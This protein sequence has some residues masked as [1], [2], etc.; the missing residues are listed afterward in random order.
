[1]SFKLSPAG[2]LALAVS[3]LLP[4]ALQAQATGH[5]H[6]HPE[7]HADADSLSAP[8][9]R[10]PVIHAL[11]Q[12]DKAERTI[13]G[14]SQSPVE[15]APVTTRQARVMSTAEGCPDYQGFANL[16]GQ[17][18]YDFVV[19]SDFECISELYRQNDA[20]AVATY[21]S[22]NVVAVA[23]LA[24][25]QAASYDSRS[26]R[27]MQQLFYFLRG[28]FYIEFYND[29]LTYSDNSASQAVRELLLEYA[30]NPYLMDT[31]DYAGR[32][33]SEFFT[34]WDS[35]YN[36]AESVPYVLDY[37]QAF[38]P[39]YL[40]SWS[41]RSA[42]TS[43][44]TVLYRGYWVDEYNQQ[45]EQYG[46]LRKA[47]LNIATADYII[48]SEYAYESSD[49]L[50][51][52]G[53]FYVYHERWGLSDALKNELN[54]GIQQYMAKFAR[55]SPQWADGAGYLDY[56]NPGQCEAFGIC[57]WEQELEQTVLGINYVCSDSI[58]IRAQA[59]NDAEL[60]QSCDLMAAEEVLFHQV[61][62]TGYTPVADD[63]NTSL[64]V[65][66]FDDYTNYDNYA[67][68]I[69]G[70]D[71]NNGGMYLE[72]NP[73]DQNNQARFIAHE[74]SWITDEFVVWNLEHEYV[75]YLDGR[76]NLY[77]AFNYFDINTGKS[78]WWSE[79]LAEYLSRQNRNDEAVALARTGALSL[80][81]VLATT[82]NDGT[83][84]VYRWGYL[85]VRFMFE[86]HRS[87]VD[88]M[89]ALA[90]GGDAQGWLDY[91]NNTIADNYEAEW[92]QWLQ[93]VASNDS[94]LTGP[95]MP[96][97]SDGDGVPDSQDAFPN[98]P[99]ETLDTDG[100]GIG[101]NAD[102]DDDND[103]YEDSLDLFPLD[104]TEWADSDGDGIG[105][106]A[107][108][109]TGTPTQDC[110]AATITDGN[111]T[112]D[113]QEC[114]AGSGINYY[115][116]YVDADNTQ[117]TLNL[118]GGTGEVDILFNQ[119][120]WATESAFDVR[121]DVAGSDDS[122]T[123][124]AN[125]GWVYFSLVTS[126]GYQGV[127]MTLSQGGTEPEPELP[128]NV[129]DVCQAQTPYEYGGVNF[130]EAVCVADGRTSYYFYVPANTPSV[131]VSTDHGTGDLNLYGNSQTWASPDSFEVKSE[132]AGNREQL[133]LTNPAEGWYYLAPRGN[134]SSSGASL[135]VEL[136]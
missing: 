133:V 62:A 93:A 41:H 1:M 12:T 127:S 135:L 117:L 77:G 14:V 4:V 81:Q 84:R 57:G 110:G 16:K 9:S 134:P 46:D 61:L 29:D 49:A 87:D 42:L 79:G 112:P 97:D 22:E 66:I 45:A 118:S 114:V 31:S 19:N 85:A 13:S 28:A 125:R 90:R 48:N 11:S 47:L 105:D 107:D 80:S 58:S 92:Q 120:I 101:N 44:L 106:N 8:V 39:E 104:P 70:I 124:T 116:T 38:S 2:L 89:L 3:S 17:D 64:Q 129:P 128:S 10:N 94:Q 40:N 34:T 109:D 96:V 51:E 69:F 35:S 52:Y 25:A 67:G 72:G 15:A 50:G 100:D 130:G 63:Y 111:L 86:N 119:S 99:S 123:V 102:T 59:M 7:N 55:M 43:A 27:D 24:R 30:K 122:L 26:G 78:V 5:S 53:R 37:L 126:S 88:A 60:T 54:A 121:T 108:P 132:Q 113:Q 136:K 20:L 131:T 32:T 71:T 82:Y 73:A 95:V 21:Q 68:I 33:L 75:H 65:N 74:A 23:N 103:G 91:I 36:M 18:L 56:Y 98:D 83:D 6:H 76:F 115:Y